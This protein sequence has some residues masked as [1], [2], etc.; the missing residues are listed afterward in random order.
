MSESRWI[1]DDE[2]VRLTV[3][4]IYI[5]GISQ[6]LMAIEFSIGGCLRGAGDTKYP[7]F[8]TLVGLIGVRVG[9]AAAFTLFGFSVVWIYAALIGDYL[10]KAFLLL[11]R[12][13]SGKWKRVFSESEAKYG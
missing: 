11:R 1:D 13:Q 3:I 8:T 6:P 9:L 10:V 5:L 7:L 12:F 2:V 4:F